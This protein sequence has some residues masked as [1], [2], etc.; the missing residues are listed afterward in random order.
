VCCLA[1]CVVLCCLALCCLVLWLCCLVLSCSCVMLFCLVWSYLVLSCRLVFC[2]VFVSVLFVG[3]RYNLLVVLTNLFTRQSKR[4]TEQDKGYLSFC[5][6]IVYYLCR[7]VLLFHHTF[8]FVLIFLF[9]CCLVSC[10]AFFLSCLY[11]YMS[12]LSCLVVCLVLPYVLGQNGTC[13]VY[14]RRS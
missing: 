4:K 14:R 6:V 10:L 12:C 8:D 9:S 2:C 11:L 3:A 1:C 13:G 5:I 7:I